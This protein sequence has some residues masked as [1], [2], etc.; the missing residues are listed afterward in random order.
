MVAILMMSAK[1]ATVSLLKIKMFWNRD[2]D[3]IILVHDVTQIF[4]RGS[5]YVVD[6]IMWR[7]FGRSL[8]LRK[9]IITSILYGFDQENQFFWGFLLAQVQ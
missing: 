7:K 1:L 8:S 3:A 9:V 2:Y 4:S 5:N 6:A